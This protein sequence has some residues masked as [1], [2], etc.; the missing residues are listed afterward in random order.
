MNEDGSTTPSTIRV[1]DA[2][3]TDTRFSPVEIKLEESSSD[4]KPLPPKHLRRYTTRQLRKRHAEPWIVLSLLGIIGTIVAGSQILNDCSSDSHSDV[5]NI[6]SDN[7]K[8][9]QLFRINL[10]LLEGLSFA[11]AKFIDLLWDTAVGQGGRFIHGLVLHQL[12]SRALTL[13]LECSTLPYSFFLG[14]KFSTVSIESLWACIRILF[15]KSRFLTTF[16]AV[17]LLFIIGHV[18]AFATIWGAATGYEADTVPAYDILNSGAFVPKDSD[19][20]TTCWSVQV[21]SQAELN[22]SKPIIGPTFAQAYGSWGNIGD[23][24]EFERLQMRTARPLVETSEA[25]RNMYALKRLSFAV[26]MPKA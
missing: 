25:F 23:K 15:S 10:V 22:L 20:L 13:L 19:R 18:L 2:E 6:G 26:I 14:V 24:K 8:T 1:D 9:E 4:A 7:S 17:S 5:C 21:S 12:V 16:M 11:Q 3:S